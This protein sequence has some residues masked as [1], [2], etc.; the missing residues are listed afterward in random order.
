[1]PT[2][3]PFW[4][5]GF[6]FGRGHFVVN[7]PYDQ[8]LPWIFQGEEISIGLRGFTYGY[9]YYTPERQACYHY[10]GRTNVPLFWENTAVYQGTSTYGMN[11]LNAI[12]RMAAKPTNDWI[13][14]DE[15]KYG[16][17]KVRELQTFFDVFGIHVSE[18]RVERHLCKF[19]GQPMQREF[20]PH[21]RSNGMGIDY[22][23]LKYR[24]VDQWPNEKD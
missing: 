11:R 12:I 3:E 18:Q 15:V 20:I 6:S 9:D 19:V 8:H 16:I 2:I 21:L 24:F 4:A 7:V 10:Y 22:S 1:M 17:G 5:A 23:T 13:R 14:T